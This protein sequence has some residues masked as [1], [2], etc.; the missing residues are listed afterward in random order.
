[1]RRFYNCLF[2][3]RRRPRTYFLEYSRELSYIL[4][5]I[6]YSANGEKVFEK[7]EN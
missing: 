4:L 2:I 6:T 7:N 3:F 5:D 1:M